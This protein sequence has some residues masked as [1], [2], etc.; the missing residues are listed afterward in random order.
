MYRNAETIGREDFTC[1]FPTWD[2][3]WDTKLKRFLQRV[4]I[5]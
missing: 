3:L 5:N 4:S 2:Q 1:M